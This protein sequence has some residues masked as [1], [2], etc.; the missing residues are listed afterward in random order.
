[1]DLLLLLRVL[2][3]PGTVVTCERGCCSVCG[4][5]LCLVSVQYAA[6]KVGTVARALVVDAQKDGP[7][8]RIYNGS[9][10]I[11]EVRVFTL[12]LWPTRSRLSGLSRARSPRGN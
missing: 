6:I 7:S 12:L 3:R 4:C 10:S 11:E 2:L 9:A 8:T 1:M 5:V